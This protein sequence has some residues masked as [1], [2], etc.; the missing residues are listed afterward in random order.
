MTSYLSRRAR[1]KLKH[2]EKGNPRASKSAADWEREFLLLETWVR[3]NNRCPQRKSKDEE[4]KHLAVWVMNVHNRNP[5]VH[6]HPLQ[7][8]VHQMLSNLG[9]PLATND[10]PLV[11]TGNT[12]ENEMPPQKKRSHRRQ[13]QRM[14][15]N[16]T[17]LAD[18]CQDTAPSVHCRVR[19]RRTEM[20][21][22]TKIMTT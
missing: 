8:K 18:L 14:Q 7:E 4:E 20:K 11:Q 15:V 13:Q 1:N 5:V 17:P 9:P 2:A 21:G 16:L 3:A 10:V 6:G 12:A 22:Y 19:G